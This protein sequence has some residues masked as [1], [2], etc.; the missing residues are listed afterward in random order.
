MA[1]KN[2]SK[3]V[4][5]KKKKWLILK[6]PR[7]FRE[8]IVGECPVYDPQD[9]VGKTIKVNLMTILRDPKKQNINIV[10]RVAKIEG[11]SAQTEIYGYEIVPSSIKRLIKRRKDKI[12][13]SF[14]VLSKDGK[15]LRIK[16]MV[17]LNGKTNNSVFTEIRKKLRHL[18][19]KELKNLTFEDFIREV[20]TNKILKLK[21][22]LK[23]IYPVRSIDIRKVM[24]EKRKIDPI[25]VEDYHETTKKKAGKKKEPEDE[26]KEVPDKVPE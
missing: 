25:K 11:D 24:V 7:I 9:A 26:P 8:S 19:A 20:M 2:R 14:V 6:A 5:K 10:L 16:P 4:Q 21:D 12:D 3:K 23:K 1:E 13:D 22:E 17:I 15:L 18:L